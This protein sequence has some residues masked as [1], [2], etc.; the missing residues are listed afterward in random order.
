[1]KLINAFLDRFE[2]YLAVFCFG[3]MCIVVLVSVFLRYVVQ[4][5]FPWG[6]E[7]ARYL[8]VWGIFLGIS[9]GVRKKAHLGVEAFVNLTPKKMRR[10]ISFLSQLL[11]IV[12]YLWMSYLSID[13]IMTMKANGQSS[14]SMRIPM[15]LVYSALP[16]GF[17]LASFRAIQVFWNE[18]FSRTKDNSR[19]EEVQI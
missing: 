8:M 6:E 15:Y 19:Y 14:P 4:Y 5:P 3:L 7:L 13:L 18:F 11:V 2:D 17:C 9:T 12:T 16:L 10:G 1:M